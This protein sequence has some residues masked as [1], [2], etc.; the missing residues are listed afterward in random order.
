MKNRTLFVIVGLVVLLVGA[1]GVWYLAS[2]LFID[3][4]VDETFPF[5]I[6]SQVDMAA[7][8][9]AEKEAMEQELMAAVP[10]EEEV[11]ALAPEE[12]EMVEKE[13]MEAVEAVMPEKTME[14]PMPETAVP[15]TLLQ[16]EFMDADSFHMGSGT[17]IIYQLEDGRFLLR[18]ENFEA[19]NGP[20]LHVVLSKHPNP[21]NHDEL[22]ADYLDLGSL[23]GNIGNQNYEIPADMDISLYQSVVIYC[24]PFQV[25]FATA[26]LQ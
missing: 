17:A 26:T 12:R 5:E 14:E 10:S 3:N 24:K 2:P 9:E 23:K 20:D 8:S 1:Y 19:T 7:M 25:V 16:G 13:V 21:T 4:R 6:P 11:A 22:G 18:F 15:T